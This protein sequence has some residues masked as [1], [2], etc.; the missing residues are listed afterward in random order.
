MK[1]LRKQIEI[2]NAELNKCIEVQNTL[3]DQNHS[4]LQYMINLQRANDQNSNIM[5]KESSSIK[6]ELQD[7]QNERRELIK[8]I[9]LAQSA[10]EAKF[11]LSLLC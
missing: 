2:L 10:K 8:K 7:L 5:N 9:G 3:F 4:L 6:K 11:L 1:T